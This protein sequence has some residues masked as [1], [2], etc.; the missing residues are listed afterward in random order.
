MGQLLFVTWEGDICAVNGWT[1]VATSNCQIKWWL[2]WMGYE[3]NFFIYAAGW[4][5]W[6]WF[7]PFVMNVQATT[8]NHWNGN[9]VWLIFPLQNKHSPICIKSICH[10]FT[11]Y[12][13]H[14][15]CIIIIIIVIREGR[16]QN[17]LCY[18]IESHLVL[19]LSS[20]DDSASYLQ[21]SDWQL[22]D[23]HVRLLTVHRLAAGWLTC[24][25]ADTTATGSYPTDMSGRWQCDWQLANWH[26]RPLTVQQHISICQYRLVR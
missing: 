19:E 23:W 22:A 21:H 18:C 1:E 20:G 16:T 8:A 3:F 17:R 6:H 4:R 25:A 2:H 10:D 11:L 26:V 15:S 13:H 14:W 9:K 7:L 24:E 5:S 12:I